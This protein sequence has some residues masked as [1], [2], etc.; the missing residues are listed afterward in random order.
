MLAVIPKSQTLVLTEHPI[1][2]YHISM[3]L[4]FLAGKGTEVE[5]N[6][7]QGQTAAKNNSKSLLPSFWTPSHFDV[8]MMLWDNKHKDGRGKNCVPK[9]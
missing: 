2:E 3:N 8:T 6:M 1:R 7:Y 5:V 4:I 9:L